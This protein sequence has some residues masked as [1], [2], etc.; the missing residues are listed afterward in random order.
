MGWFRTTEFTLIF[1]KIKF[2]FRSKSFVWSWRVSTIF[3]SRDMEAVCTVT[4]IVTMMTISQGKNDLAN[5]VVSVSL[6]N[7]SCM[8]SMK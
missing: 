1:L 6:T 2:K 5:Q 3:Y 8:I 7:E 4:T